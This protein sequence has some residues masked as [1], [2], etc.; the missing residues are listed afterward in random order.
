[1]REFFKGWRRKA[2]CVALTV[3]CLLMAA[4]IRSR[5]IPDRIVIRSYGHVTEYWVSEQS[6]IGWSKEVS[7]NL[8]GADVLTDVPYREWNDSN[9][10]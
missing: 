8:I 4:W 6:G 1:M 2:G 9:M 7:W 3:S 10:V 5:T